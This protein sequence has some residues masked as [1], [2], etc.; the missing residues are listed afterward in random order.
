M[1]RSQVVSLGTAR[2][3]LRC[4]LVLG[5]VA[6]ALGFAGPAPASPPV[7]SRALYGITHS[8]FTYSLVPFDVDAAGAI[9]E[10]SGDAIA[11]IGGVSSIV[12]SPDGR[13]VYIGA[14]NHTGPG[15][16]Y[17]PG[18]IEVYAVSAGGSLSLRQSIAS[19]ASQLA[20]AP[21]GSRL[22]VRRPDWTI[23]S[24]AVTADG[25]LGAAGPVVTAG[26]GGATSFALS[27]DGS[28]MY[29]S[30]F[31]NAI[32][33][34]AIGADGSLTTQ[35]P[36]DLG[37]GGCWSTSIGLT[38]DG[39]HL[40]ANCNNPN[41]GVSF[42]LGAGGALTQVGSQYSEAAGTGIEDVHGR[43]LYVAVYPHW[44]AQDQRQPDGAL[45]GFAAGAIFDSGNVNSVAVDPSGARLVASIAPN[46]LKTYAI[47]SDGSLSTSPV[48]TVATTAASF[49]RLAFAPDQAPVAALAATAA[50][51]AVTFD[52]GASHAVDG[53]IARYD[54]NFGDGTSLADAG[55]APTHVYPR[56]GDY[57]A[58]V[59]VT[60]SA[61]CSVARVSN[62]SMAICAGSPAAATGLSLH[63]AD[64]LAQIP[65]A[66]DTGHSRVAGGSPA[67]ELPRPLEAAAT[68][69]VRGD[70][71]LVTWKGPDG[72]P[73]IRYLLAWSTLHSAHG[74]AD[75]NMHHLYWT[76][77]HILLR[78]RPGTTLHLAVYAQ[79]PGG[80]FTRATKTTL[81]LR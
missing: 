50:G 59:T 21:D 61:G 62:G 45:A 41:G 54:W 65:A 35:L 73:P 15:F 28:T 30:V 29:A 49:D 43:A 36:T 60:D 40:D 33:Q 52:A 18:A 71:V 12:V 57:T 70:K 6:G 22:F 67:A 1:T 7:G 58:R 23:S 2:R 38:P 44:I 4:A 19:Q 5:V 69:N 66:E 9:T 3:G 47:A 68:P 81:R 14:P 20:L 76:A 56:A 17:L 63:L 72:A 46:A 32:E 26:G 8:G 25:S 27:P 11:V 64:A 55:P 37:M 10:R 77:P 78:T 80:T 74:P 42:A 48:A 31:P 39:T 24:Y 13:T 51:E 75:P 34:W 79:M 16:S 53:A